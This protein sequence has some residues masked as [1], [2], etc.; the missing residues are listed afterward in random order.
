[1]SNV[2]LVI[3]YGQGNRA[4]IIP[5]LP[6]RAREFNIFL[7]GYQGTIQ[8]IQKSKEEKHEQDAEIP[9]EYLVSSRFMFTMPMDQAKTLLKAWR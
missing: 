9:S 6:Y 5:F 2:T 4:A 8:L 7:P 3:I 1:M